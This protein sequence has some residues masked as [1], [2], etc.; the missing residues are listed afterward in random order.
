MPLPYKVEELLTAEE[1]TGLRAW[2]REKRRTVDQTH[3][4][5]QA[6]GYTL[7][8]SAVGA[9]L[10]KE[11]SE[12]AAEAM[13]MSSSVA[14]ALIDAARDEGS[15]GVQ[16]AAILQLGHAVVEKLTDLQAGG[17]LPTRDIAQ[18]AL[19]MQRLTYSKRQVETVRAKIREE[20][21]AEQAAA[22]AKAEASVPKD[23]SPADVFREARKLLGIGDRPPESAQ[24]VAPPHAAGIGGAA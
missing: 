10:Q 9:W 23:A 15:V 16:D 20:M 24:V 19:S 21:Q 18:L 3:E 1:L 7:S 2:L 14:R 22:L 11:R 8:R 17:E 4:W 6:R 13:R 12:E 5:L